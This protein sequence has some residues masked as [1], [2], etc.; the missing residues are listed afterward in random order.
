MA[1]QEFLLPDLG[2]G[3]EDAEIVA[4]RVGEG[5]AVELNQ[6]VVEVNTAKAM[7]EIPA[8]WPGVVTKLHGSEG[9]VVKVGTPL[10]SIEV[11][12][13]EAVIGADDEPPSESSPS[14]PRRQAVLVG[15]GVEDEDGARPHQP[16]V[17]GE[18]TV[19]S[20]PQRRPIPASPPVRR[21]ARELGVDLADV[22]G[23]GPRGR[24]TREDVLR[25]SSAATA[26][27]TAAPPRIAVGAVER[28]AVRGTR[29]LIADK[30]ARSVREIPHVT[31]F[32]TIDATH[33]VAFRKELERDSGERVTPLAIVVRALVELIPQHPKLNA[34]FH[35]D[36]P[37]ILLYG[38][39]H[40]GIATDTEQG[41]L[42]P[43]IRDAH[44]LG[45]VDVARAITRLAEAARAGRATLE[46]LTGSTITVSNVGSFG[47]EYGTPIINHPEAAILAVGV[48]EPKALVRDGRVEARPA[49]VLSLSFDHRVM[50]GA[51]AG[52]ALGALG[53]LLE[54]PFKLGALPHTSGSP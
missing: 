37:E 46:E 8:P 45:V 40:V 12:G 9:D 34:S 29:R 33:V 30:M 21:L 39:V 11:A 19:G 27:R 35:E 23:S 20:E 38:S 14:K 53:T 16:V 54:S 10:V 2:E 31:T 4:W 36:G 3:L 32:L 52:R 26:E 6:I 7:V 17:A 13:T 48:I 44:R 1:V 41:L 24:V 50:D 25:A 5:D 43:V 51:E 28:L 22:E 47:S 18:R 49:S 15:Y 42:A